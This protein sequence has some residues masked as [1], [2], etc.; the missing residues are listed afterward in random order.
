VRLE[1]VVMVVCARPAHAAEDPIRARADALAQKHA[2]DGFTVVLAPP[3]VVVGN[4]DPERVRAHA[5]A[6]KEALPRLGRFFPARVEPVLEAW[7]FRDSASYHKYA[8]ELF[9][10]R[11]LRPPRDPLSHREWIEVAGMYLPERQAVILNIENGDST[12]LHEVVHCFVKADFPDAPVWLDEGLAL[13]FEASREERGRL[14]GT[15]DGRWLPSLKQALKEKSVPSLR[16]FLGGKGDEIYDSYA[17]QLYFCLWLQ[18]KGL[19]STY[20][21]RLRSGAP[22]VK[23]LKAVVRRDLGR[24]D[25]EWRAWVRRLPASE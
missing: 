16:A 5:R 14:V 12:L 15:P 1:L 7:V 2:R 17:Q 22:A 11:P 6:V 10:V 25:R 24:I 9:K 8:L 21:Q 19:L 20:Y 13:L 3:F 4:E 23:S 18:R